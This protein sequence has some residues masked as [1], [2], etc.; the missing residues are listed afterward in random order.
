MSQFNLP[1]AAE[2]RTADV[3]VA[4]D[5]R[6]DDDSGAM[7]AVVDADGTLARGR[8]AVSAARLGTGVRMSGKERTS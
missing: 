1:Q 6:D 2:V 5:S 4:A 8:K 3:N 7:H